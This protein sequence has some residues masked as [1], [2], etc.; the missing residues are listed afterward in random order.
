MLAQQKGFSNLRC[1]RSDL[2]LLLIPHLI[3]ARL[4]HA[5][6]IVL[7]PP[8]IRAQPRELPHPVHLLVPVGVEAV[9][10]A[11]DQDLLARG[12]L[13]LLVGDAQLV[14]PRDFGVADFFPFRAPD[15]VLGHEE[16]VAEDVRVGGLVR[17]GVC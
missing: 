17:E 3:P 1:T 15:E 2:L 10:V 16:G 13:V 12:V 9:R 8:D 6:E 7:A 4:E 11:L 5:I 14:V